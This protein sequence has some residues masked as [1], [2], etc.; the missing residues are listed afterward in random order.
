MSKF[1]SEIAAQSRHRWGAILAALAIPVPSSGKHGACPACGGKDRFRFD[2]KEGRGTW[3]CNH[4]G[5]GDGLDLV[6]RVK[7][8]D[9]SD[10]AKQVAALTL[11]ALT[12]PAREKAAKRPPLADKIKHMLIHSRNGESTYLKAKGLS[13]VHA[14]LT[15]QQKMR[16][17]GVLFDEGSLL[18]KL[19]RVSGELAGA[20]LIND[21]GEKRL[22]PGSQLKGSFIAVHCP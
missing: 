5:H 12:A 15:A 21:D 3:F 16:I 2:D 1:V 22:L 13:I 6:T 14:L 20:Q 11:P 9:L 4:C 8:C 17:G 19:H 10:A 18:L 7:N